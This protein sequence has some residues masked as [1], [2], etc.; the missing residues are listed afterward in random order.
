[1][2]I[3]CGNNRQNSKL[4]SGEL[5]IGRR[6][7]CLKKGVGVGLNQPIDP[8]YLDNYEPLYVDNFFCGDNEDDAPNN[9]RLG[10]LA[11][12][13]QKGV[14]IGKLQKA[15]NNDESGELE[16]ENDSEHNFILKFTLILFFDIIYLLFILYF[17]PKFFLIKDTNELNTRKIILFWL[18]ITLILSILFFILF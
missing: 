10:T 5:D 18:L 15:Q 4:I 17:K 1:M 2:P 9:Y 13:L 3:Y 14:A 11:Q 12:C 6:S 7:Q 16:D 8:D